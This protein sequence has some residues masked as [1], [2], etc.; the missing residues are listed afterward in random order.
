MITVIINI[1]GQLILLIILERVYGRENKLKAWVSTQAQ[2]QN[3]KALKEAKII[4]HLLK[5]QCMYGCGPSSQILNGTLRNRN[6]HLDRH[7]QD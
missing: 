7:R 5:F 3:Q 4:G 1:V 2:V 6:G